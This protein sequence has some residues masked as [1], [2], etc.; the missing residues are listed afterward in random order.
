MQVFQTSLPGKENLVQA[1]E[2]QK[3]VCPNCGHKVALGDKHCGHCGQKLG[4]KPQ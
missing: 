4:K 3:I 2:V 1:Q